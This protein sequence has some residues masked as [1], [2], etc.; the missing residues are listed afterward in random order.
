MSASA[1]RAQAPLT[2][3]ARGRRV[4]RAV[5]VAIVLGVGLSGAKAVAGAPADPIVVDTYTVSPGETLW[6]IA[7]HRTAAHADVRDTISE[8][9]ALNGLADARLRAGQ[10]I[11]V[12][13][14]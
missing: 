13:A 4:R 3:T 14:G 2:L 8:L 9:V 6:A 10:Q 1:V 5:V 7:G 11:L 12:P